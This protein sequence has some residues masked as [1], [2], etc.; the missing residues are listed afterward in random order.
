M[1][2][3]VYYELNDAPSA[4]GGGFDINPVTRKIFY[5]GED[6]EEEEEG[7]CEDYAHGPLFVTVTHSYGDKKQSFV[8]LRPDFVEYV[9]EV[10]AGYKFHEEHPGRGCITPKDITSGEYSA[11]TAMVIFSR[12]TGDDSREDDIAS[13]SS[14]LLFKRARFDVNSY[15]TIAAMFIS[16]VRALIKKSADM[17]QRL[18]V[19]FEFLAARRVGYSHAALRA[20]NFWFAYSSV[21]ESNKAIKEL[22]RKFE[23]FT[24]EHRF[25]LIDR[26]QEDDDNGPARI[27]FDVINAF[28]KSLPNLLSMFSASGRS[29]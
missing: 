3:L 11:E 22:F 8:P 29:Y 20:F 21:E 23:C 12:F 1:H 10:V 25:L 13:S 26:L 5:Q 17:F 4:P 15:E 27:P 7:H 28:G 2:R 18:S 9:R 24:E 6:G 14:L 16:D 19:F